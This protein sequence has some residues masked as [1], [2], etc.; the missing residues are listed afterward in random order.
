M[1][2]RPYHHLAS[3]ERGRCISHVARP[4]AGPEARKKIALIRLFEVERLTAKRASLP[5][6][7]SRGRSQD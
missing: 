2:P 5:G 6:L 1:N 4:V 3:R 7:W